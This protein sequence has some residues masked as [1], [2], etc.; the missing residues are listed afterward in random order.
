MFLEDIVC[1]LKNKTGF[2]STQGK[3]SYI[4]VKDKTNQ[5]LGFNR[6]EYDN[7]HLVSRL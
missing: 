1:W 7:E 5:L 4:E 6:K 3:V 2:A